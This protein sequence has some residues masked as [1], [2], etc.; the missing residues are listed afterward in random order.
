MGKGMEKEENIGMMLNKNLEYE[1][2]YIFNKKW[3]GKGYDEN[4]ILNSV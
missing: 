3:N 2:E 1:G 4:G